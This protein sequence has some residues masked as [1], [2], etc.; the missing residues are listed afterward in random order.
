MPAAKVSR[1][2]EFEGSLRKCPNCGALVKAFSANCHMCGHE[3]REARNSTTVQRFEA[4]YLKAE[5]EDKKKAIIQSLS[6]PNTREDVLE[7]FYL[8]AANVA[9]HSEN[10]VD[11]DRVWQAKMEQ[12][13][14][15]AVMVLQD[16]T[17]L[18]KVNALYEKK[19][20]EIR[21]W[22]A[23][24]KVNWVLAILFFI[25]AMVGLVLFIDFTFKLV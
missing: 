9:K 12:V 18:E 14:M 21:R 8:T 4:K 25:G 20:K 22:N 11:L 23:K 10:E 6:V 16:D 13:Y 5:S 19:I 17:E 3:F 2:Y 15:K 7:L 1:Q 24:R